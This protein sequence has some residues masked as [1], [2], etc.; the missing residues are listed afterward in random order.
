MVNKVVLCQKRIVWQSTSR[1][2]AGLVESYVTMPVPPWEQQDQRLTSG[3][4]T[5]S[6][7]GSDSRP[8][9]GVT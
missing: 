1:S 8:N 9:E 2:S 5:P 6:R 3:C 7:D 4:I